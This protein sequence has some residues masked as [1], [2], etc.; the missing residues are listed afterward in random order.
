MGDGIGYKFFTEA[1]RHPLEH[2][3]GV[4]LVAVVEEDALVVPAERIGQISVVFNQK[5]HEG[6]PAIPISGYEDGKIYFLTHRTGF[7]QG[8]GRFH[9]PLIALCLKTQGTKNE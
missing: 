5:G 1:L 4:A 7:L 6:S 2:H 9:K 8:K 3:T